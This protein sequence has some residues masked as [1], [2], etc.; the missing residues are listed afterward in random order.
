MSLTADW[1][2]PT[3]IRFGAGRIS[4]LAEACRDAGIARP[5]VVTDPGLAGLPMV[6]RAAAELDAPVFSDVQGN[7]TEANVVAG[8]AALTAG[9]HDGVV[10]I[11]GGSSL[12]VGKV[13]AFMAGQS[14]P[15]WDFEDVGDN[16]RRADAAALPVVAV[17]TTAGTGSE[18]GRAGVIT[19]AATRTKRVIF[20]PTM[21]PVAV[22]ADPEL[23]VGLPPDLT[24]WTGL[25]AL[26]HALEAYCAP[27]WHPLAEGIAVEGMRLVHGHLARAVADGG[28]LEARAAMLAAA[29]MG[30]T[31]FQKGLGA[32]HALSHPVSALYDCHHGLTNAVVMPYVVAHSRPAIED[33]LAR[34]AAWPG[35]AGPAGVLDWILGLRAAL[36]IPHTLAALGV[37]DDRIEEM[38]AMAVVDP[39]AAGNPVPLD[40]A[41]AVRL[42]GAAFRGEV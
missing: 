38:A 9:G 7:P 23:T 28:D 11:G 25:D 12:D 15:M 31:A 21:M 17:P 8:I 13:V 33:K 19:Q 39:T 40:R 5:L 41:T 24:A 32:V 10:A 42:Y 16:W 26:A 34:L 30:A 29:A 27:A 36:G 4:E 18:V 6:A 22:I 2:I 1:A 3:A 37:P 14:R 20:H 35:L